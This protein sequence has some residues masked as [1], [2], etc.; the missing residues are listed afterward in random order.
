MAENGDGNRF[1][2]TRKMKQTTDTYE[3]VVNQLTEMAAEK[4]RRERNGTWV[5]PGSVMSGRLAWGHNGR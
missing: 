5:L 3:L 4:K 1:I 2:Y